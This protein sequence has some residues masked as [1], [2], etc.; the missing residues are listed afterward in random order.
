MTTWMVV[1]DEPDLY[2]M[3][4]A[5]YDTLGVEGVAFTTG[6]EAMEWIEAVDNGQY[7]QE[8]PELVL[9]D[10]RLPG[11]VNGETVSARIRQSHLMRHTAI[12]MMTAYKMSPEQESE[13]MAYSGADYLIYKPLP[14]LHEFEKLLRKLISQRR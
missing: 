13:I 2:E 11:K 1:E 12:V 8:I 14:E 4:L 7:A 9:L 10:I 6:E 5:M 3:V